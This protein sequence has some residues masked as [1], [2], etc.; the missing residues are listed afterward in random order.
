[1]VVKRISGRHPHLF[2]GYRLFLRV[3]LV[4][5]L[6]VATSPNQSYS[7]EGDIR[8]EKD[9]AYLASDRSEKLDI[10]FPA[11]PRPENGYPVVIVI[12]GGGF[13]SGDKA[14]PRERQT[15]EILA[16]AGYFVASINFH[17]APSRDN[18]GPAFPQAIYDCQSAVRWIK[19]ESGKYGLNRNRIGAI[20]GSSGG[21]LSLR[22]ASEDSGADSA[23]AGGDT[24]IQ[25]VVNLYG[26][27]DRVWAARRFGDLEKEKE[28]ELKK[29][30]PAYWVTGSSPPV[31]TL[32]GTEDNVVDIGHAYQLDKAM[33]KA[34]ATHELIVVEGGKHSFMLLS[35]TGDFRDPVIRFF[36]TH[37][38]AN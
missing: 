29:I 35:E 19:G 1:M 28:E 8:M 2:R 23:G 25:A 13:W 26:P 17:L 11:G 30:S 34:G 27:T 20:G 21:W 36:D 15:A 31:M 16:A 4:F 6:V 14:A 12:H 37:L 24:R 5:V 18:R 33:K 3:P 38:K 7:S 9:V 22:L 10:Y 32:H